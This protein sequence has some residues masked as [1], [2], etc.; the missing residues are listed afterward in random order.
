MQPFPRSSLTLWPRPKTVWRS[1]ALSWLFCNHPGKLALPGIG[2]RVSS[3]ET[4]PTQG[5]GAV[6]DSTFS[7][8]RATDFLSSTTSENESAA[9]KPTIHASLVPICGLRSGL[10]PYNYGD[11]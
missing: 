4:V 7:R 3:P 6:H 10:N 2:P 11:K 1:A 8:G 9:F 5:S